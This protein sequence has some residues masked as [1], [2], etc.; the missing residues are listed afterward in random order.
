MFTNGRFSA[1][2]YWPVTPWKSPTSRKYQ[3]QAYIGSR[4]IM[5]MGMVFICWVLASMDMAMI[6]GCI[7]WSFFIL[8]RLFSILA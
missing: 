8:N 3:T 1:S 6:W 4:K 7:S 2:K 5:V